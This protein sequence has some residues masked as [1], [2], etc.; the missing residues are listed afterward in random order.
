MQWT[1]E[2]RCLSLTLFGAGDSHFIEL[3]GRR[4]TGWPDAPWFAMDAG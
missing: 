2:V 1:T 4:E 3:R